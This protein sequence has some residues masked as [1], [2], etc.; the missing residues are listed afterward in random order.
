MRLLIITQKVDSNDPIL[1]FFHN[2]ILEFSKKFENIV[3]ICLYK[4]ENDLPKNVRVLSLGKE[5]GESRLKYIKNLF[6]FIYNERKNYDKVF[7]HMNQEYVLLSGIFLKLMNKDVYMW[8]NHHSGSKLTDI[9]AFFCKKV[10][11]TSKF[12]FTTKYKKTE[13]MPVGIDLQIFKP[14]ESVKRVS[15][16]LLFLGRISPVKRPD[17]FIDSVIT[18]HS[19][20][21]NVSAVICGDPLPI[22]RVYYDSLVDVVKKSSAESYIQFKPGIK[23][24]KTVLQYSSSEIF[25]NLSSSGMYDKTIFE[26]IACGCLILASN[27]NLRGQVS[28]DFIFKQGD[29][30]E[31]VTK[32]KNLLTYDL[33]KKQQ[34]QKQLGEFVKKHSLEELSDKLFKSII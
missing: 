31:L 6:K 1:S 2:W 26:A 33:V 7:V 22:D 30:N 13:I 29:L 19:E 27:D 12:S 5:N 17:L 18:A 32:I 25:I 10:F 3:V 28:D 14:I 8:R 9:A 11:C 34:A 4:G 24:T 21:P 23:N 20:F 16:S 15:Q